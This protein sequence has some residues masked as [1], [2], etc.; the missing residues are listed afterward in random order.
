[1]TKPSVRT[2]ANRLV[3]DYDGQPLSDIKR[4]ASYLERRILNRLLN[5]GI[6]IT[7]IEDT[8]ERLYKVMDVPLEK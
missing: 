7:D 4:Q 5:D 2:L 6:M 3:N 8:V 1:M